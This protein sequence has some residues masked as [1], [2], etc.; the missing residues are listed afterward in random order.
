M[1]KLWSPFA[2][3]IFLIVFTNGILAQTTQTKLNQVELMKQ[4][5]GTW[6]MSDST[7]TVNYSKD[8]I[9]VWEV[10]QYGK[11][12]L[13]IS[14][15]KINGK[16]SFESINNLVYSKDDKFKGFTSWSRGGY[17][18]QIS[19]FTS[20]KK[21]TGI[22]VRNF[23]PETIVE[24]FEIVFY[25]NSLTISEFTPSGEKTREYRFIKVN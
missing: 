6:Q 14:Y 23:N 9:Q 4:F 7:V 12:F 19:S 16:K 17:M 13:I 21:I 24:K 1:K 2:I 5:V 3:T 15:F 11:A 8:T 20:E 10:Q 22:W 25:T 18:T